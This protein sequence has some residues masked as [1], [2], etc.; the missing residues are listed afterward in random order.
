MDEAHT[1]NAGSG[2]TQSRRFPARAAKRIVSG[3]AL[4]ASMLLPGCSSV[5]PPAPQ[6]L[7]SR[8]G[9]TAEHLAE[10]GYRLITAPIQ[11]VKVC[12]VSPSGITLLEIDNRN[13]P[14]LSGSTTLI[15]AT[16]H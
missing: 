5:P 9:Y 14:F 15:A 4:C 8:I 3:V 10:G 13:L 16:P 6:T 7:A 1:H 12:I 11:D 2:A